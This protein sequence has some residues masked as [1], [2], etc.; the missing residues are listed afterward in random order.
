MRSSLLLVLILACSG[1]L[2]RANNS[3]IEICTVDSNGERVTSCAVSS[4]WSANGEYWNED[5]VFFEPT[6][7]NLAKTW[8]EEGTMRPF[9]NRKLEQL[10]NGSFL[11][12]KPG[13]NI[14]ALLAIDR[15]AKIG[16]LAFVTNETTDPV[17]VRL[18]PLVRVSGNLVCENSIPEWTHV[19][20]YAANAPEEPD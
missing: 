2:D 15:D 4:V 6:D 11:L 8:D 18:A 19:Y 16:G 7:D 3:D 20:V 1:C 17:N 12:R 14:L 13:S 9:P 5:G 10:K